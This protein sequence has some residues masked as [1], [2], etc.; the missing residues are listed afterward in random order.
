MHNKTAIS[1]S[2]SMAQGGIGAV[3]MVMA[4]VMMMVMMMMAMGR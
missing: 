1:G 3:E 2:R 4:T